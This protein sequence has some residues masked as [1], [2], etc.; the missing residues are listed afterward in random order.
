[1]KQL[2]LKR[3]EEKRLKIGHL[4]V[5]SNE[6]DTARSPLKEFAPGEPA[7]VVDSQG[8]FIAAAYV[9][10]GSL[11]CAR[12]TGRKPSQVLGPDLIRERLGQALHLRETLFDA[13]FYRLCFAEADYLPGLIV[14]RHG[15]HLVVQLTTAGMEREK[16]AVM[17]S[18]RDLLDPASILLKNDSPSRK[19]ENLPEYVEPGLGTPPEEVEIEENGLRFLA[20]LA[21]GQKTGWFYDQRDNRR[22]IATMCRGKRVLDGFSY[23]GGFGV[24]A[25]ACGAEAV[26]CLDA[27]KTALEYA[28]RNA[29]LNGTA[30]RV[31][32]MRGDFFESLESLR[33]Q[34]RKYDVI[35]VDPPAFMKSKKDIKKGEQAYL[36]ANREAMKL[37]GPD[38]LV[39]SCSC[40]QHMSTDNL[41][42]TLLRAAN[43]RKLQS[44]IL[45]Q[46]H[47][48]SDHPIHPAMPETEYL[49]AYLLRLVK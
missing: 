41:R 17:E 38:G 6:V 10:P 8:R 4:W 47:Q 44:Q 12:V 28:E 36:K 26:T 30:G 25:A 32:T 48:A 35:I 37:L 14:D 3:N 22:L 18:L 23:A 11:I 20:P 40:S 31:E 24:T 21:E 2:I 45:A 42:R 33:Q 29:E 46:G 15:D 16:V 34:D 19:L 49:K 9:N 27:S 43:Q 13:P 5:F 39:L 1:M 7:R